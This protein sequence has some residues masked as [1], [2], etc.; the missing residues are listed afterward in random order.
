MN[1]DG[2]AIDSMLFT[3]MLAPIIHVCVVLIS[4]VATG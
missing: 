1:G 2:N 4:S 3:E